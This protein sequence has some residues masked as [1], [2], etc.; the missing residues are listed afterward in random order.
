MK[1]YKN[2]AVLDAERKSAVLCDVQTEHGKFVSIVPAGTIFAGCAYECRGKMAMLP[3]FVNGH[4]HAPMTLLRG[5]GEEM[6]LMEWLEKRMWPIEN[7]LDKAQMKLGTQL[8]MLEMI[9]TGTTCYAEQYFDMD[10]IP[11]AVLDAGMRAG[12]SRGLTNA[13]E[14][15]RLAENIALFKQWNGAKGQINIQFGPHALYTVD[16]NYLSKVAETAREYDAGVQMHWLET[17]GEWAM[18][19]CKDKMSPE[20]YLEKSGLAGAKYLTLAH[21]VWIGEKALDFYARDNFTLVHCPKSNLKLGSGVAD[22]PALLEH[23]VSVALGTDGAA[24]N[25]RLDM[26][27]EMRFAALLNK[28]VKSDPTL[29]TAAEVLKM[30]TVSGAKALGFDKL[31]LIKEGW[32]ADFMLVD[33]DQPQ[34]LGWNCDNLAAYLVYAGSSNDIRETVASGEPLYQDG[35]FLTLDKSRILFEAAAARA[36]LTGN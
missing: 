35:E 21:G 13:S 30:A 19:D 5:L 1:T 24:S 23:G 6:P 33:L 17:K 12:L 32:Q 34:Y 16:F 20:E 7:R 14:R 4:G 11:Q 31:G 28:G 29:V 3:G 22:V 2:V 27:D 18:C 15:D 25:N 8:A 36:E 9:S 26:W 10:E